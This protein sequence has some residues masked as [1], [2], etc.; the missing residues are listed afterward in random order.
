MIG[1]LQGVLLNH[2][3]PQTLQ[4]RAVQQVIEGAVRPLQIRVVGVVGQPG[5]AVGA[6]GFGVAGDHR[7]LVP[8]Q[9]QVAVGAV[10][11]A[12]FGRQAPVLAE[13]QQVEV[14]ADQPGG[15][16]AFELVEQPR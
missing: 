4:L 6:A 10:L 16:L 15:A 12:Q 11:T 9:V 3:C 2:P 5:R 1:D 13:R 8:E 14:A 7:V